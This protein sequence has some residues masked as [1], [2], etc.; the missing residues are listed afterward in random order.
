MIAFLSCWWISTFLVTIFQCR[1]V[2]FA[3]HQW[4]RHNWS[5][6]NKNVSPAESFWLDSVPSKYCVNAPAFNIASGV[7]NSV[8]DFLVYLW[9]IHY[10]WT[11]QIPLKRK[12][13]VVFLFTIGVR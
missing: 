2:P 1:Y 12:L 3:K 5:I 13:G 8:S 7:M 9:P 11:I 6:A 10:L 4:D